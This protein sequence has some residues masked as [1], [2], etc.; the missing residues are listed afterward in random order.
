RIHPG[1]T[2][3][4]V[5]TDDGFYRIAR[6]R[7]AVSVSTIWAID[8]FTR[9]NGATQIIPGSHEWADESIERLLS[10]VDF[11]T[12]PRDSREPHEPRA[13]PPSLADRLVDVTMEAGSVIVF[14]GTLLHRGG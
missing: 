3:Q 14:L 6:P 12:A 10:E 5:H 4:P 11:A 7:D 8:P 9:E 2:A 13:L 1:E